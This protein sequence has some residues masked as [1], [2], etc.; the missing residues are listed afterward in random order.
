MATTTA[1][2]DSLR[3]DVG[4]TLTSLPDAEAQTIF[5][6]AAVIYS[7]PACQVAYT[8][9]IALRQLLA[10]AA[11]LHDYT[12]NNSSE[13]MGKVFDNYLKLLELWTTAL[14][15][16]TAAQSGGGVRW[17]SPTRK[18]SRIQEYPDDWYLDPPWWQPS[19]YGRSI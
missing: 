14:D 2:F 7:D 10:Q 8:R 11:T 15:D 5:D 9:V 4:A 1:D 17:G 16:A 6:Q 18:P 19:G 12:A 3:R 13:K